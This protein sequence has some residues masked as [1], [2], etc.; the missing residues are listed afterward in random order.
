[1]DLLRTQVF[2]ELTEIVVVGEDKDLEF[3]AFQVMTPSLEGFNNC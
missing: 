2:G 1:M 3:T